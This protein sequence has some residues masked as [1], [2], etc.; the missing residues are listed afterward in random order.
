MILKSTLAGF[1]IYGLQIE[2]TSV[3]R[4]ILKLTIL[5]TNSAVIVANVRFLDRKF[6]REIR[7]IIVKIS[8]GRYEDD[9][10][11]SHLPQNQAK[12]VQHNK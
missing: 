12:L 4:S 10:H 5:S 1:Q 2:N 3:N 11:I 7:L 9:I 6:V 8:A